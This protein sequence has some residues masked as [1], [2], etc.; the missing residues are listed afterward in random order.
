MFMVQQAQ[1]PNNK[2]ALAPAGCPIRGSWCP[3]SPC[4]PL[5]PGKPPCRPSVRSLIR[6]PRE[7]TPSR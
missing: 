4:P 1:P 2:G 3:C 5:S 7:F 6:L